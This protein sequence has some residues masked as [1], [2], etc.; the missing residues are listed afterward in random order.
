[1][2]KPKEAERVI[3]QVISAVKI[4]RG[5]YDSKRCNLTNA[6][7]VVGISKKS[8]DDYFLVLRVGEIL[9]YDFEG[10]LHNMMGDLRNFIRL[11]N[12]KVTGKLGKTVKCFSLVED[13]DLDHL[14]HLYNSTGAVVGN[15]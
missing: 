2:K 6:A 4:W 15:N 8:L 11:Q 12:A 10:N 13:I 5:L 7:K 1:M 14:M 9:G 3:K